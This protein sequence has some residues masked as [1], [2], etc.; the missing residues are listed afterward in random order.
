MYMHACNYKNIIDGLNIG[1][2]VQNHQ[3]Q[4][5]LLANISS[6]AVYP[7]NNYVYNMWHPCITVLPLPAS[8]TWHTVCMISG[9]VSQTLLLKLSKLF[10][11]WHPEVFIVFMAI[12]IS[13]KFFCLRYCTYVLAHFILPKTQSIL[14]KSMQF[15]AN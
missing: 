1:N 15:Q 6:Y 4:N 13:M 5:L 3:Y 10:I 7:L 14:H 8:C 2:V 12:Y 9:F 11:L